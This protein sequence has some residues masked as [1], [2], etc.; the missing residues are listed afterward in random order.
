L[1]ALNMAKQLVRDTRIELRK[2]K[3]HKT[4]LEISVWHVGHMSTAELIQAAVAAISDP[5][6]KLKL[7]DARM[8]L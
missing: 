3:S 6:L 4:R 1:H 5:A 2:S 8:M 7:A